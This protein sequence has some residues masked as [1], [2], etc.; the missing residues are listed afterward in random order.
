MATTP[1]PSPTLLVY[2]NRIKYLDNETLVPGR[3]YYQH[4]TAALAAARRRANGYAVQ[5]TRTRVCF[6][7]FDTPRPLISTLY[8]PRDD[9]SGASGLL[10]SRL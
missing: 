9:G 6:G 7:H 5:A 1:F 2:H 10:L 4:N 8:L 3:C